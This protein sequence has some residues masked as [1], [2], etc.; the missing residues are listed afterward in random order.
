[1]NPTAIYNPPP[2]PNLLPTEMPTK[3]N[4]PPGFSR[5]AGAGFVL[6]TLA[7]V[8]AFAI[9]YTLVCFFVSRRERRRQDRVWEDLIPEDLIPEQG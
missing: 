5:D 1:M 8:V 2:R 4:V 6:G 9:T 3:S 7:G